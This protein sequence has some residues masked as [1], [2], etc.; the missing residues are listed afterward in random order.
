MLDPQRWA[1]KWLSQTL[2]I[3]NTGAKGGVIAELDAFDDPDEAEESWADP[4]AIVWAQKGG[5][6]AGKIMPRPQTPMPAGNERAP[7]PGDLVDPRRHRGQSRAARHG[8]AE[9]ARH[10]RAYAASR[11]A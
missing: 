5:V 9:P 4:A 11:P 7:D 8:R 2:H 1:N 3:L 6:S 10:R